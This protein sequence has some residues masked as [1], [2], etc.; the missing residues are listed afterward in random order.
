MY[1]AIGVFVL[2]LLLHNVYQEIN[3]GKRNCDVRIKHQKTFQ[4]FN[5]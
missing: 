5:I 1:Y 2:S 3:I 4:I